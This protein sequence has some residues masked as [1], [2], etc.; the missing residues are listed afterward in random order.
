MQHT[1]V[2]S[3]L[4]RVRGGPADHGQAVAVAE[5]TPTRW[6]SK[7]ATNIQPSGGSQRTCDDTVA[8]PNPNCTWM[9]RHVYNRSGGQK[10]PKS[11]WIDKV[12][13]Q[14]CQP[15]SFYLLLGKVRQDPNEPGEYQA[16]VRKTGPQVEFAGD[17]DG[18][19]NGTY[20]INVIN[21][22]NVWV[23]ENEYFGVK[24]K[25]PMALRCNS[26]SPNVLEF[27]PPLAAGGSY[28]DP[29]DYNGCDPMIELQYTN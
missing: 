10:A 21:I 15:G 16:K 26:G 8:S 24:S 19:D 18:C 11:G 22:P 2:H 20:D 7:L 27:V 9:F 29:D 25:R 6:G 28:Q 14:A 17:A 5:A 13:V 23:N 12:R 1:T 4:Q 3:H